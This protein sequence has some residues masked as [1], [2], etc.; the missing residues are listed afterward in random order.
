MRAYDKSLLLRLRSVVKDV[1]R[2]LRPVY[3]AK[4]MRVP[5]EAIREGVNARLPAEHRIPAY[6][7][8]H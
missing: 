8:I 2:E 1:S 3:A 4:S 5:R 7:Q 6:S